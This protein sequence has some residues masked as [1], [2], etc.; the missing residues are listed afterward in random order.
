MIKNIKE[1]LQQYLENQSDDFYDVE[2]KISDYYDQI[3]E[4]HE[5]LSQLTMTSQHRILSK[6]I[7]KAKSNKNTFPYSKFIDFIIYADEN[8]NANEIHSLLS[9]FSIF[10][11]T[12][13]DIQKLQNMHDFDDRYFQQRPNE[14]IQMI[15]EN[16]QLKSTICELEQRIQKISILEEMTSN[17]KTLQDSM[18]SIDN[19][20]KEITTQTS[21]SKMFRD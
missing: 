11:F 6:A 9:H 20:I 13:S 18:K 10:D 7:Q 1:I 15:L 3:L 19:K 2:N 12:I 5:L 8:Q 4:H 17:I 21:Y 16:H 14:L